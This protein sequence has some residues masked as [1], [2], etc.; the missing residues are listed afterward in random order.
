MRNLKHAAALVL[1]LACATAHADRADRTKPMYLEA[2]HVS[3]DDAKQIKTFEGRVQFS[4]GTILVRGDKMVV[5]QDAE[6]NMHGTAT[7]QPVSFRQK[8][9][10][11]DE[12]INGY[13]QR[14]EYDAKTAT[15]EL[16]GQARVTRGQDE[17][18]GEHITYN[19]R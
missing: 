15:V 18:R 16:Y 12:Y 13:G 11:L 17:V 2:D 10:G 7:G 14:V 8:R 19:A 3:I 4:Q 1:A 9:D 6:G 5:T